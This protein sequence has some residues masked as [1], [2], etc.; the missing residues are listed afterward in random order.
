MGDRNADN[1]TS[2]AYDVTFTSPRNSGNQTFLSCEPTLGCTNE[3]CQPMYRQARREKLTMTNGATYGGVLIHNDSVLV[4]T[5]QDE[6]HLDGKVQVRIWGN[7]TD[8]VVDG[9]IN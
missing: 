3:G 4:D 7:S 2:I 1:R 8:D 6:T 5:W 9:T